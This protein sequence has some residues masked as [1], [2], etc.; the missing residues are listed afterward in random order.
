M[1]L[2]T[3]RDSQ[4]PHQ[5]ALLAS[6]FALRHQHPRV[7]RVFNVLVFIH[8]ARVARHQLV[9][10]VDAHPIGI[11]LECQQAPCQARWHSIVV[12][13]QCDA[14]LLGGADH[15]GTR[16]IEACGVQGTQLCSL[17]FETIDGA[18]VGGLVNAHIGHC[19]YP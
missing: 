2:R 9:L 7:I 19:V 11:G 10:F 6:A 8:A 17:L 18:L 1:R 3:P 15:D 13:V 12:G 14:K 4:K 16:Q 5:Q